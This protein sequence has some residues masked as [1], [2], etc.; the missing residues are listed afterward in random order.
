MP[1]LLSG[2]PQPLTCFSLVL[3]LVMLCSILEGQLKPL[4]STEGLTFLLVEMKVLLLFQ[5]T[6]NITNLN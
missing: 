6:L 3:Q 5:I 1:Q 4:K 2:W